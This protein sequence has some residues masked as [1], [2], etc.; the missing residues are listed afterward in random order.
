MTYK[1]V[2]SGAMEPEYVKDSEGLYLAELFKNKG[3][4][5]RVEI[6]ENVYESKAIKAV[7]SGA[8]DPDSGERKQRGSDSIHRINSDFQAWYT[9]R[10]A[11]PPEER[12]Q[13]VAFFNMLSQAIR[14]RALT[15]DEKVTVRKKQL[16][17]FKDHQDFHSANPTCYFTKDEIIKAGAGF[18][19]DPNKPLHIGELLTKNAVMLAERHLNS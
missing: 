11:M 17:W 10:T 15:D 1:I 16:Q 18:Q 19:R 12:A 7:I 4:P 5:D 6:N 14:G 3:F 8:S 9:L 13:S 2:F